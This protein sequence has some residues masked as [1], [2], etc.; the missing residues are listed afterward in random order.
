MPAPP[1]FD[2]CFAVTEAHIRAALEPAASMS[3]SSPRERVWALIDRM[4]AVARPRQ[5]APKILLVL[6]RMCLAQ[7]GIHL[8]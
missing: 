7:D 4:V 1:P 8:L 5:G 3:D 2:S 6:A